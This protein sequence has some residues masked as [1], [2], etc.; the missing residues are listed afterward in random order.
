MKGTIPTFFKVPVTTQVVTY[1]IDNIEFTGWFSY[2]RNSA[3]DRPPA[4]DGIV[5]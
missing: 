5:E 4:L 3:S 1:V 2:S